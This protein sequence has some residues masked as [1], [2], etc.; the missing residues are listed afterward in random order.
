MSELEEGSASRAG[1]GFTAMLAAVGVVVAGAA[2]PMGIGSLT[3]PG[4]GFFPFIAG[5]SLAI[6][7]L[8]DVVFRW[9]QQRIVPTRMDE[10]EPAEYWRAY[11]LFGMLA[12]YVLVLGWAGFILA[13][14]P[15]AVGVL[16]I[17]ART[18]WPIAIGCGLAASVGCYLLFGQLLG[19]P[20]A[21]GVLA[22]L[23]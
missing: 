22:G 7:A 3:Q 1:L 5:A 14:F 17:S 20:L 6:L 13:T 15:L 11:A 16:W 4:A 18:T 19:V 10:Q 12:A 8:F 21:K 2:V 23:W 9:R